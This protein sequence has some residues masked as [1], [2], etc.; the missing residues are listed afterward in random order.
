[1]TPQAVVV[2]GTAI[3]GSQQILRN[4]GLIQ[5]IKDAMQAGVYRFQ[6]VEGRI[7]GEITEAG[8]YIV[9]EG[10]KRMSAAIQ[11]FRETGNSEFVKNLIGYGRWGPNNSLTPTTLPTVVPA[12]A[13]APH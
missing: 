3:Y 11:I 2:D 10:H 9:G 8:E 5:E 4:T 12:A 13:A 6:S 1:M 7:G